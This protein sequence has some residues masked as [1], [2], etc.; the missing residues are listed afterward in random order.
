MRSYSY[1]DGRTRIEIN[2]EGKLIYFIFNA[3][4]YTE[5]T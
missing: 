5:A 1:D 2:H 4:Q 3:Y